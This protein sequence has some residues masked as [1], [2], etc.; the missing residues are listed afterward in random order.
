MIKIIKYIIDI[1]SIYIIDILSKVIE[2]F[3]LIYYIAQHSA[4]HFLENYM[5][6][7]YAYIMKDKSF[8]SLF[9]NK[10]EYSLDIRNFGAVLLLE[11]YCNTIFD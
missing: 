5:Q 10:W 9:V 1:I 8:Y 3:V 7:L 11:L 6:V 2:N 4:L